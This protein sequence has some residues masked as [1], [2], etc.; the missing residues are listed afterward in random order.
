MKLL[1]LLSR[2]PWPVEK[3]DKLRAFHQIRCLSESHEVHLCAW[4]D[5][6]KEEEAREKLAAYCTSITFI[7]RSVPRAIFNMG[8]AL[9]SG[10]PLQVG[11]FYSSKARKMVEQLV[12]SIKPDHIYCQLIRV[13]ELAK[14]HNVPC[15]I[16]YQ[17][18]MSVNMLRRGTASPFYLKLI[19]S[20]E[21][22]RLMK[23]EKDIFNAF[24]HHTII[25]IPDRDLM[26]VDECEKITVIPNGVDYNYFYPF[27]DP[28]DIDVVFTG[29]MGYPPNI[30]GSE[31]LI[32]EIMPLVKAKLPNVVFM[33]AGANPHSRVQSL[34]SSNVRVTGWVD[35]IR[36]CYARSKVFVAPMRIG[37][38]LQNK[39]LE[40]MA[41]KLPSVTTT[42]ANS[43][44]MAAPGEQ[45]LVGDSAHEIA[46]HII[47]LLSNTAF[48]DNIALNGCDFVHNT[49]SW[50]DSTEILSTLMDS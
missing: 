34:E 39:L 29:N 8:L 11:M 32:R 12:K 47:Q 7:P 14:N 19:M 21:Y 28:K 5:G 17:D 16:D 46:T 35:D 4:S 38:G 40:A 18:V 45:I 43:A 37:T 2:V 33:I 22:R 13:A 50:E 6:N 41:M 9:L 44:L 24:N 26:P 10:K 25:S 31:F 30:D 23:Y 36:D 48:A 1:I 42:L 20:I 15:T 49:F 27:N 3:G